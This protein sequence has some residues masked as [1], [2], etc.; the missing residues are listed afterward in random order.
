MDKVVKKSDL[1]EFIANK[2]REN[3]N[4]K[5]YKV[6]KNNKTLVLKDKLGSYK[7]EL[8]TYLS[9]D[10]DRNEVSNEIIP[11]FYRKFNIL[12]DW[13][14][15]F[16]VLNK[17]D[18]RDRHSIFV[19]GQ[20]LNIKSNFHFLV[21]NEYFKQDFESLLNNLIIGKTRFTNKFDSLE[22]LYEYEV[23][24]ILSSNYTFISYS[25][26][27]YF[28]YLKLSKLISQKEYRILKNKLYNHIKL[29]S[30]NEHPHA[31]YYLPKFDEIIFELEKN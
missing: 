23:K 2:L 13:F 19:D 12:H 5:D 24:P 22:K 31:E 7:I 16:S 18:F 4:F 17:S 27:S 1:L 28:V 15:K 3:T 21:T 14:K 10:F 20:N 26:D 6:L 25:F 29:Q 11:Y 30:E 9:F 8:N